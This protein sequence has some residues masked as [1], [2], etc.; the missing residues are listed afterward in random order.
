MNWNQLSAAYMQDWGNKQPGAPS[1][2]SNPIAA[3]LLN[4]GPVLPMPSMRQPFPQYGGNSR[5]AQMLNSYMGGLLSRRT[6][7]MPP[8]VSRQGMGSGFGAPAN[9]AFQQPANPGMPAWAPPSGYMIGGDGRLIQNNVSMYE[10]S[11]NG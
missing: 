2:Q 11:A 10:P 6:P 4:G 5:T 3:G 1:A 7:Y 9:Y 8:N